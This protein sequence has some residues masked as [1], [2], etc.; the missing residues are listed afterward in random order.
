V[1]LVKDA[2]FGAPRW[3]IIDAESG[4]LKKE[5]KMESGYA[6]RAG[7]STIWTEDVA[8]YADKDGIFL[9]N[10]HSWEEKKFVNVDDMDIGKKQTMIL[11]DQG[12]MVICDKGV[13][14]LDEDGALLGKED[15]KRIQGAVWNAN[16]CLVFTKNGTRALS[17]EEAKSIGTL[18]Y[19]PVDEEHEFYITADNDLVITITGQREM[20]AYELK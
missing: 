20:R 2:A 16:H 6:F 19:T 14:F 4:E 15:F 10:T 7:P 12:L 11:H 18:D 3:L 1:V 8:Y 13:A 9:Y 5:M 17:M